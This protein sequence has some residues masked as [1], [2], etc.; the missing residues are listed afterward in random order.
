M[1]YHQSEPP[2]NNRLVFS[3]GLGATPQEPLDLPL[4]IRMKILWVLKVKGACR[5]GELAEE[6]GIPAQNISQHLRLMHDRGAVSKRKSGREVYYKVANE[7]FVEG[8]GLIRKGV[9][10]EL[11]K[12]SEGL[13]Q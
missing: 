12:K 6:I 8:A 1:V 9:I 11:K 7:N 10:Q 4:K 13:S 2:L 5:V 3:V